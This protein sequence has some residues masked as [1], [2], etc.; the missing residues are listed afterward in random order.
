[1]N[2]SQLSHAAGSYY[3]APEMSA[4]LAG[5][6]DRARQWHIEYGGYLSNHL[7]HNWVVMGAAHAPDERF[8]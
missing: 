4:S 7:P 8:Q 3:R 1:M 2:T 5:W 6:L